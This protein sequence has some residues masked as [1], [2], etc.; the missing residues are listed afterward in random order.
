MKF[1]IYEDFGTKTCAGYPGSEFHMQLD[2]NTFAKW[3]VDMLKF[4]GCYSDY[5]DDKYGTFAK[6]GVV[7]Y[8][9]FAKWGR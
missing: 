3:G 5:K 4:D 2:A 8:I 7:I 9:S 6:W 1:C